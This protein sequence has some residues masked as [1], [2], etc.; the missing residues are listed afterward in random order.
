[1]SARVDVSFA[2]TSFLLHACDCV[3]VYVHSWRDGLRGPFPCAVVLIRSKREKV[4]V[5]TFSNRSHSLLVFFLRRLLS[6]KKKDGNG[7]CYLL[8]EKR[9]AGLS[10]QF[11]FSLCFYCLSFS[12]MRGSSSALS[13]FGAGHLNFD[14]PREG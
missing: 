13:H 5:S 14:M 12:Y 3:R 1:M 9:L 2:V 8:T 6:F 10:I 7:L 11:F 4:F